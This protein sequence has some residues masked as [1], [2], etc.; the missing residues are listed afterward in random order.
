MCVYNTRA[1]LEYW[2]HFRAT[3]LSA[4]NLKVLKVCAFRHLWAAPTFQA[5][6]LGQGAALT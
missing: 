4:F 3:T 6:H 5:K 1:K 2:L